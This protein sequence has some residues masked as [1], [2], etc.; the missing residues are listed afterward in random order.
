MSKKLNIIFKKKFVSFFSALALSSLIF[1]LFISA[2]KDEKIKLPIFSKSPSNE[3]ERIISSVGYR[4]NNP[5]YVEGE[6]IIKYKDDISLKS[7]DGKTKT[8]E[9]RKS[10]SL[11]K[12]KSVDDMNIELVEIND[13]SS[14][15]K[16]ME[17]LK[18]YNEVEYAEPNYIY[19]LAYTPNDTSYNVQWAI[20]NTGQTIEGIAGTEDADMDVSEMWDVETDHSEDIVVA[21]IDTGVALNHPDISSNLITGYDT[22]TDGADLPYDDNGHGTHISGVIAALVNNNLGISGISRENN[23]KVMPIRAGNSDGRFQTI[24]IIEAINYAT[25]HNADILNLS[26]GGPS[27]SQSEYDALAAF[28]GLIVAAAGNENNDNDILP[29]YPASFNLPNIISVAATDQNDGLADFSNYG[30][31]SVD[32]GAPGVNIYSLE[33]Y[34]AFSEDFEDVTPPDLGLKFVSGGT[35]DNWGTQDIEEFGIAMLG[36]AIVWSDLT[37]PYTSSADSYLTSTSININS[38]SESYLQFYYS[39]DLPSVTG[40]STDYIGFEVYDGSSWIELE[41]INYENGGEATYDVTPYKNSN[42]AIRFHWH[43]DDADN[44]YNGC[45][46]DNIKIIDASSSQGSYQYM[47]GTSMATPYTVAAAATV[48][49]HKP[50]LTVAQLKEKILS[51]GESLSSLS[52]KTVSGKR[53][54]AN[55]AYQSVISP[56]LAEV[57]R[58][59]TT[60]DTTPNYTFSSTEEG[61]ISYGGSCTSST[62]TATAGSNTI[63]F[64]ELDYGTYSNC[65][66]TVTDSDSNASA[67]LLVSE[68]II[69]EA[70][71]I[72]GINIYTIEDLNS[73][74]NNLSENYVLMN[75][76]DFDNISSYS[77]PSNMS[78]YTT[79]EGWVPIGTS[80]SGSEF[81][82]SFDGNGHT[83]SNLFISTSATS[84]HIGLFGYTST[85][86]SIFDIGLLNA[87]VTAQNSDNVGI[88]SGR[89]SGV[90][91]DSYSTGFVNGNTYVGGLV[92]GNPGSIDNSYSTGTVSGSG[93]NI[94]GLV[95]YNDGTVSNSYSTS[96]VDGSNNIGGLVGGN[97]KSI[98]NSYST[99]TVSGSGDNVGGLAG[100]N[101]EFIDNSYSTGTVSG[102]GV[103]TGGLVG[104][105]WESIDNSY[106][107]GTVSGSVDNTGGLVGRSYGVVENSYSTSASTGNTDVGGLVGYNDGTVSNSYST[108]TVSGSGDDTG[109]LVGDNWGSIDNS[110]S[111]G[112]VSGSGD[113]TGGLAGAN[114]ADGLIQFSFSLSNTNGLT[115]AGGLVGTNYGSVN[116]SYSQ[117][118]VS[119]TMWVGGL[120]GDT[121]ASSSVTNTYSTGH[122]NGS[123]YV[124]GLVGASDGFVANSFYD[125]ETSGLDIS[126]GGTGKTTSEMQSLSTFTDW[127]IIQIEDFDEDDPKDWY[128]DEDDDYPRLYWEFEGYTPPDDGETNTSGPVFHKDKRCHWKK[129][130]H[131]TWIKLEPKT[132]NGISGMY[133]TWTQYDA[134]KVNIKIDDGTGNYPWKI[135]NTSNDGH[136]FLPNVSSWQNIMIKPINHC[137]EGEYSVAINYLSYPRGW[138][139]QT[140]SQQTTSSNNVLGY[141]S[142]AN[143]GK[144][145]AST[146]ESNQQEETPMVPDTG[147]NDIL[148]IFLSSLMVSFAIY[149]TSTGKFR[150]LA[151]RD[152]EK[153][154]LKEE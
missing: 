93:D 15:K 71:D 45:F 6:I 116:N 110:Y 60:T 27:Y 16:K 135:S 31:T 133:L 24:D 10:K 153:K 40:P 30:A 59:G 5:E 114:N 61:T 103:N 75:D 46:I 117:G 134:D 108:G 146:T 140:S 36:T 149:F 77:D 11:E 82:G 154:S 106:S 37:K 38:T 26:F 67:P 76:L 105:N 119:G 57:S 34:R 125:T 92:G 72:T 137:K 151:L 52:G 53:I 124:G 7:A 80:T 47:S 126:D 73:I 86:S 14:V 84:M 41:K 56:T 35:G 33:G 122:V 69:Q 22:L 12:I 43:T 81:S 129:P 100:Y 65:T 58:I 2:T 101:V 42:F 39:C 13:G 50:T 66:I 85:S 138:Y 99:G 120:I 136:E 143:N 145:L 150:S 109:G 68:F 78:L 1:T 90:I 9:I 70:P 25:A 111:T 64:E 62:I 97:R 79:G 148:F 74:R 8:D 104:G 18:E 112:T 121:P 131:P 141:S 95:G 113:D 89:N 147:N 107:T 21:V 91:Y 51:T 115:S 152:F 132:E 88:L 20:K 83:I 128:I 139:G 118:S 29:T 87:S 17:E 123:S 98:D 4:K 44:N 130:E 32:V 55:N 23:V 96:S 54:N 94:G 28:P 3:P 63:T 144:V 49:G 19:H 102:G 127:D 48:W 142:S